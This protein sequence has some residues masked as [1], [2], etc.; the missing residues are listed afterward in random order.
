MNC[1]V[2]KTYHFSIFSYS[3]YFSFKFDNGHQIRNETLIAYAYDIDLYIIATFLP[4]KIA[5]DS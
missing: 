3:I 2:K 5:I 4:T 1:F